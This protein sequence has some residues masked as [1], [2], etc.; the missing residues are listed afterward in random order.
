MKTFVFIQIFLAV[1]SFSLGSLYA[2][3]LPNLGAQVLLFIWNVFP[4]EN[5][6]PVVGLALGAA[7][8]SSGFCTIIAFVR[9]WR[10][11]FF[12]TKEGAAFFGECVANVFVILIQLVLMITQAKSLFQKTTKFFWR[13]VTN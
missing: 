13:K 4:Y 5:L 3:H 6:R 12:P 8:L 7:A 1:L 2:Y 9:A 11:I 10:Y